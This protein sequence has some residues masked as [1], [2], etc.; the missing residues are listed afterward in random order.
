M[1]SPL[2]SYSD[3]HPKYP[4]L[5]KKQKKTHNIYLTASSASLTQNPELKLSP[6]NYLYN[7]SNSKDC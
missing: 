6:P 4:Q 3:F 7:L 5:T 1:L 2:F